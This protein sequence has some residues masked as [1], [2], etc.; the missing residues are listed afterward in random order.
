MQTGLRQFRRIFLFTAL[1]IALVTPAIAAKKKRGKKIKLVPHV[2]IES[3]KRGDFL[4]PKASLI[5]EPGEFR[6]PFENTS[7]EDMSQAS[8]GKCEVEMV[9]GSRNGRRA[10]GK[11][12][13]IAGLETK[14]DSPEI[15]IEQFL[16]DVKP[17]TES[18]VGEAIV[19]DES[20]GIA[21]RNDDLKVRI[22]EMLNKDPW[23]RLPLSVKELASQSVF[24]HIWTYWGDIQKYRRKGKDILRQQKSILQPKALQ[25]IY[26]DVER[27]LK[28]D[29]KKGKLVSDQITKF[30]V[31]IQI[32]DPAILKIQCDLE[33]KKKDFSLDRLNRM[34]S[35]YYEVISKENYKTMDLGNNLPPKAVLPEGVESL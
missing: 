28:S 17:V 18:L 9:S 6:K 16:Q 26:S 8:S 22:P 32:E 35:P 23:N 29:A 12:R 24:T 10:L 7:F 3:L 5:F 34:L 27:Y 14:E 31:K 25:R 11:V 33:G 15:N 30:R 1:G 2:Q 20:E 19:I 13:A 4:F 21:F